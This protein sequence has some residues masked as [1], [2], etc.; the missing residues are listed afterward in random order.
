L[1]QT[2]PS[3]GFIWKRL[4]ANIQRSIT[5]VLIINTLAQTIGAA[6][7]GAQFDEL[8]GSRWIGLYSIAL[9]I[10][11]IQW[12]EI[13]PKTLGVRFNRFIA[14]N[15]ARIFNIIVVLFQPLTYVTELI[16][17]PFSAGKSNRMD[18]NV[19]DIAALAHSAAIESKISTEQEH[20]IH[21]SIRMSARTAKEIMVKRGDIQY[22]SASMNLQEGFVAAHRHRHTRYPLV[23]DGN[24]DAITGY[25]NMKDIIAALQ[26]NPQAPS[27]TGIQRPIIDIFL[28]TR[29]PEVMKI[30]TRSYQHIAIVREKDGST[31][32]MITLENIIEALV[33][34]IED[35][36]DTPPDYLIQLAENRWRI[37]GGVKL[38]FLNRRIGTDLEDDGTDVNDWIKKRLNKPLHDRET[39][40]WERFRFT[41]R[42]VMRGYIHDVIVEKEGRD[43]RVHEADSSAANNSPG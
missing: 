4:T 20:L 1:D 3:A 29:L 26:I 35:E 19:A 8:F 27:L 13:L 42:R 9:S 24:L 32:G 38:Q 5:A 36:F 14:A 15:A 21:Q 25:V 43:A 22:L 6:L 31:A 12:T 30:L 40:T 34:D 39:V 2:N 18:L 11:M 7:S 37:G 41:I 17:R 16:N 10:V 33:G 28:D 23:E